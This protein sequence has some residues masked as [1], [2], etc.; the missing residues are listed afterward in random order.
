MT[1]IK[2]LERKILKLE[3]EKKTILESKA[4]LIEDQIATLKKFNEVHRAD[5]GNLFDVTEVLELCDWWINKNEFTENGDD[6]IDA[7]QNGIAQGVK[8][9]VMLLKRTGD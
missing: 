1:H 8:F 3:K 7:W 5:I 9:V 6:T 4:K 2:K